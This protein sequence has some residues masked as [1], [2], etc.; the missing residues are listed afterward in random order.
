VGGAGVV[1]VVQMQG[2]GDDNDKRDNANKFNAKNP[3]SAKK[4]LIYIHAHSTPI[5]Q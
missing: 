3:A 2:G 1:G 5:A 4:A